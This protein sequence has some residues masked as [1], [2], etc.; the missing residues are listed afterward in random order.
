MMTEKTAQELKRALEGLAQQI[1]GLR[2]DMLEASVTEEEETI[3]HI[4]S[5]IPYGWP[6]PG[7]YNKNAAPP[8]PPLAWGTN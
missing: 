6:Q 2:L 4:Q 1:A 8:K 7:F 5:M 3:T